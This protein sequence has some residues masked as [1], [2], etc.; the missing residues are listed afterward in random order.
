L[1]QGGRIDVRIFEERH[2][3]IMIL[4]LGDQ[5]KLDREVMLRLL[6]S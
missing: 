3:E 1:H 5:V 6:S 4:H 2:P